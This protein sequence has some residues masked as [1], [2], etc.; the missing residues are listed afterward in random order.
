MPASFDPPTPSGIGEKITIQH[1]TNSRTSSATPRSA[2]ARSAFTLIELLVVI[3][4]I[5]ILAAIL[6]PVF[7]QAREKARQTACLSNEKQIGLALLM[8]SQDFDEQFPSG[9]YN[10]SL[11]NA[12]DWGKGWAGQ[13]V[14]QVKNTQLFRCPDDLTTPLGASG[15]SPA[16]YPASYVYNYN[17][18]LN[19]SQASMNAPANTVLTAEVT[20]DL[21]NLTTPG[22]LPSTPTP[23]YS[24]TGNGLTILSAIDGTTMPGIAGPAKYDT[25]PMGGYRL[26][27]APQVPY[28]SIFRKDIGRHSEGGIFCM[29][30]GHAKFFKSQAVSPGTTNPD[31]SGLQNTSTGVAAGAGAG[32]FAVT[33]STN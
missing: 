12:V 21:A 31:P 28:P 33:F 8:Y 29:G 3:A 15:T 26:N 16:M 23:I 13:I 17:V 24:S 18:A 11:P 25:G 14:P 9:R 22:E 10:P 2:R 4:I 5:A 19:A 7:A 1:V 32:G 27:A 6:F 20:G 30:D